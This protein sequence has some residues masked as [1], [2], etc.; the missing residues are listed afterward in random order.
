MSSLKTCNMNCRGLLGKKGGRVRGRG[1]AV[2]HQPGT[3]VDKH[4]H[5][6]HQKGD[7]QVSKGGYSLCEQ[8]GRGVKGEW[9]NWH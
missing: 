7:F 2:F 4:S 1:R 3:S 5:H 8:K 9:G 6:E